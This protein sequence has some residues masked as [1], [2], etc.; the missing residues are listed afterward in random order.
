MPRKKKPYH[1]SE[2]RE[3]LLQLALT[4]LDVA[5][6]EHLTVRELSRQAGVSAMAIYRHFADRE[7]LLGAVAALG[8]EELGRR[9]SVA[10]STKDAKEGL[11]AIGVAYVAFAVE[12]PGLFQVMY[13]GRPPKAT[14]PAGEAPHAA[15]AALARWIDQLT[16]PKERDVAFLASWSLVHGLATLLVD[17]RIREPTTSPE[18]MAEQICRFF[19][20]AFNPADR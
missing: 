14:T 12:H 13:G 20:M 18:V 17:Q 15:Y 6:P 1:H 8:F 4:M 2:L 3:T 5:P 10:G 7:A 16:G 9:M 11:V 19:V